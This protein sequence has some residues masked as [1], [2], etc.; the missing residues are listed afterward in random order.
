M[1]RCLLNRLQVDSHHEQTRSSQSQ[2]LS[3][4]HMHTRVI[5]NFHLSF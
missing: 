4:L 2:Q 1:L 5:D 3:L